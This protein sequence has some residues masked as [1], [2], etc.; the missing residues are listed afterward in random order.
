MAILERFE[1]EA[2]ADPHGE[3]NEFVPAY[4]KGL[5]ALRVWNCY[6]KNSRLAR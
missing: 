1:P 6:R 5:I 3:Q 4:T 2:R